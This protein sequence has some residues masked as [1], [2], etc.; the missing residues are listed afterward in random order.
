MFCFLLLFLGACFTDNKHRE[1]L[2]SFDI[3]VDSLFLAAD[4]AVELVS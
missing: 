1:E 2:K 4:S 3:N